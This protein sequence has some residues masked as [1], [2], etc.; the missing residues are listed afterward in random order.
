MKKHID[1]KLFVFLL[2]SAFGIIFSF[3]SFIQITLACSPAPRG[4]IIEAQIDK[5]VLGQSKSCLDQNCMFTLEKNAVEYSLV[6][7]ENNIN[8]ANY[9]A[10]KNIGK[11]NKEGTAIWIYSPSI[12]QYSATPLNEAFTEAIDRLIENDI[13]DIKLVLFQEIQN[14]ARNQK[15]HFLSGNLTIAPYAQD[16]ESKLLAEEDRLL[17]CHY[18]THKHIGNWLIVNSTSRD[19]CYLVGGGGGKCPHAAISY[20]K[21]F[22]F[23]LSNINWTTAPYISIF[24]SLITTAVL[25]LIYIIRKNE[26]WIF[27][28]P[29]KNKIIVMIMSSIVLLILL[30]GMK[31]FFLNFSAIYLIASLIEY[32]RLKYKTRQNIK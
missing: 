28:K 19:Y 17:S 23:L 27:L 1:K 9:N 15:P 5:N 24:L 25:F 12:D 32:A 20:P 22:T 29:S 10:E 13:S 8:N 14:W 6:V 16:K 30:L 11:I 21:F 3:F 31:R 18:A 4:I 26:L 2:I 7:I